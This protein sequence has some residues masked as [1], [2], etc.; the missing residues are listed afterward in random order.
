VTNT[1]ADIA[2]EGWSL[3]PLRQGHAAD[4]S[5]EARRERA[6]GI[7]PA[8]AAPAEALIGGVRCLLID[9]AG[10][11]DGTILYLHG[12]GYRLGS[13][14]AYI[15]YARRLASVTARRI[16]LPFYRLAPEHPFPAALHDA[17]AVYRALENSEGLVIA[18]DSAGGGLAAAVAIVAARAGAR[19]EGAILI[20]PMLDLTAMGDSYDRN[21]ARDQLFSRQAVRDSAELYLQGHPAGDPLVSARNAD[22]AAFP[23]MLLLVGGAEVLLDEAMDFARSLAVADR[24]FS[25]HVASGMGHVWPLMA[26]QSHE[27]TEAFAA[28]GAFV[29]ALKPMDSGVSK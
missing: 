11:A 23:P 7:A 26:P 10:H 13:P 29:K 27:A 4:P 14:V 16:V 9:P 21:A 8:G 15:A 17:V 20:S 1:E 18:G 25:L 28:M 5:L 22:M 3:P 12:G 6:A 24:R 19:P 2:A